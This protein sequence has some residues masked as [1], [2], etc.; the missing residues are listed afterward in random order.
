MD[1]QDR[2]PIGWVIIERDI[3]EGSDH[4][5]YLMTRGYL[6]RELYTCEESAKEVA[7]Q[8]SVEFLLGSIFPEFAYWV[9]VDGESLT[10]RT[11][12]ELSHLYYALTG[13]NVDPAAAMDLLNDIWRLSEL[14]VESAQ[15][16]MWVLEHFDC[17]RLF[18]VEALYLA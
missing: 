12:E 2:T 5:Q 7:D 11:N 1:D 14:P 15:E 13:K 8:F 17:W 18:R 9:G 6:R 16:A 3:E 4:Q 10:D